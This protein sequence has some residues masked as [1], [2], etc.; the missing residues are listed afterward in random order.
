MCLEAVEVA[1][2]KA[3]LELTIKTAMLKGTT[4]PKGRLTWPREAKPQSE[5]RVLVFAEGRQADEAKHAGAHVVGGL[6]LVD[7]VSNFL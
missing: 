1:Y 2:T 5:E 4:L 6:E 3:T 7:D